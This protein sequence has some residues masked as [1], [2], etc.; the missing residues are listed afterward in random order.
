MEFQNPRKEAL[1]NAIKCLTLVACVLFFAEKSFGQSLYVGSYES[2]WGRLRVKDS[3][4]FSKFV[5][6]GYHKRTLYS[7]GIY[8]IEG[9]SLILQHYVTPEPGSY[10]ITQEK[11]LWPSAKQEFD[12]VIRLTGGIYTYRKSEYFDKNLDYHNEYDSIRP[13]GAGIVQVLNEADSTVL[14]I[15]FVGNTISLFLKKE[16]SKIVVQTRNRDYPI[17]IILNP[18]LGKEMEIEFTLFPI[19]YNF[20]KEDRTEKYLIIKNTKDEIVLQ[21][22]IEGL[23]RVISYKPIQDRKE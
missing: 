9:D 14:A 3:L 7:E 20:N 13:I 5:G 2:E 10:K 21:T 8:S 1:M 18:F 22:T 12:Y 19:T 23:D 6:M 15:S 11:E 16:H 17:E 4:Q